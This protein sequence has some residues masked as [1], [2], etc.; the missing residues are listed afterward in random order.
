MSSDTSFTDSEKV[1]LLFKKLFGKPCTANSREFFQEPS[2]NARNFVYQEDI[3]SHSI[4]TSAPSDLQGL[5]DSSLDDNGRPLKGSYAGKTSAIDTNIRFFYKVPL[6][7]IP[8][9]L[10]EAYQAINATTSH[11]NGYGDVSGTSAS[12]YGVSGSYGRVMQGSIPLNLAEDGSYLVT[13]YK[14]NSGVVGG[15]IPFG[16]AGGNWVVDAR[17]GT[18]RFFAFGNVSG[19]SDTSPIHASFFT[20]IG[21]T[22]GVSNAQVND[23]VTGTSNDFT[24]R[25]IFTGGDG[26]ADD[27]LSAI[28][29]DNRAL[30]TLTTGGL[31]DSLQWGPNQDGSWR[32]TVMKT[33]AGS[34][35]VIQARESGSWVTKSVLT[36]P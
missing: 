26:L 22:G 11:P 23:I 36:S 4:P 9:T 19:V 20:Y 2:I 32:I 1:D 13:I 34:E 21:V 31:M 28:Q 12:D 8:G 6:E 7:V 25:Q 30:S 15:E 10:N 29:I 16:S 33:S 24:A 17:P 14:D 35:F 27:Q 3:V 5:G 18:V